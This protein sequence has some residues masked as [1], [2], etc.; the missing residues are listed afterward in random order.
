MEMV[1]LS[2]TLFMLVIIVTPNQGS[3]VSDH[4]YDVTNLGKYNIIMSHMLQ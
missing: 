3:L 1:K 2:I 4:V